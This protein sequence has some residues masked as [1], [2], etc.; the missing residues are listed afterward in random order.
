LHA[1]EVAEPP[2]DRSSGE[3]GSTG[4]YGGDAA[5][6]IGEAAAALSRLIEGEI[7][8]RLL[9]SHE[10]GPRAAPGVVAGPLTAASVDECLGLA[11]YGGTGALIDH[12]DGLV[13][14]GVSIDVVLLDLL[15][16]C[17]RR[18]GVMW[19]EDEC[20]FADVTVGLCRLQQVVHL[21]GEQLPAARAPR[22]NALFSLTPGDQHTFPVLVVAEL[23][24]QAGWRADAA[25][26]ATYDELIARVSSRSFDLVGF[27]MAD[28]QWLDTLAGVISGV[29]RASRNPLLRVIVGGHAFACHPARAAEVGADAALDASDAV[30]I[31]A[32]IVDSRLP[33]A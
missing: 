24:R 31:A 1:R 25:P 18:L 30:R 12:V 13:A 19:E 21:I 4:S 22:R 5:P 9:L 17:A 26:D 16:P 28:E 7:I 15:C 23:F 8:P 11:L 6:P 10:D 27:S 14:L 2:A 3:T 32:T 29:R 20:S 33:L